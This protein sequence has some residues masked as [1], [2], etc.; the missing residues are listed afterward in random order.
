[1]DLETILK[2]AVQ[3]KRNEELKNSPQL[4]LGEMIL[5]LEGVKDKSKPLYIDLLGKRP[6]GID[7][8]RGS[9]CEL[10]IQTESFGDFNT[11]KIAW[12]SEDGQYKSYK[13]QKIGKENPTVEE[14]LK[15]LKEAVGKTFTGYKGGDFLMGKNTPVWLAEYGDSGFKINN[16]PIDRENLSNYENVFF[17]DVKEEDKKVYLITKIEED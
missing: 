5:K 8:W 14:W 10:A 15:V 9:Y 1:M 2:N 13:P 16:K 3:A 4:L 6:M 17:I 12:E 11:D 7:S